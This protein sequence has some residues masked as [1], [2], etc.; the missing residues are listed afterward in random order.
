DD[1][2]AL[3]NIRDNAYAYGLTI[4]YPKIGGLYK[5][6]AEEAITHHLPKLAFTFSELNADLLPAFT[7]DYIKC[8]TDDTGI[9]QHAKY[10]IPNLKE[11]YCM[12]DNSRALI[13]ILMAYDQYKSKEALDLLPI[14]LSFIQYMQCDNDN[15]RNFLSFKR[16]YLDEVG[17]DDSYGR[18]L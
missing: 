10:G 6:L 7:L 1:D 15:F 13:M 2:K 14:Y 9:V 3:K 11:G 4:R 16:E 5:T 12:D 18:T 17:T 8:L